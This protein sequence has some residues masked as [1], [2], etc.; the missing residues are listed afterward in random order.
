M[1]LDNYILMIKIFYEG[2][3]VKGKKEGEFKL[4][5]ENEIFLRKVI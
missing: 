3:P 4:L 2:H 1:D 5:G